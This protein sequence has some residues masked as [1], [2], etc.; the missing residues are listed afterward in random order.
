MRTS[1]RHFLAGSAAVGVGAALPVH[2]ARAAAPEIH[3]RPGTAQIAPEK[4]APTKIWGYEG[5]VPGPT[6]R[7]KQGER[8]VR[9]F[10]NEL[11]QASTIHWHGIRI[12]NAMDGVPGLTQEAVQTGDS[13]LYDFV[14]PDAGTYWYHPHNRTWEQLARGLYGAL[15]VEE[16]IKRPDIVC[17]A[18]P[19]GR[20][21]HCAGWPAA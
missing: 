1:R 16:H 21:D 11:P 20:M 7:V 4:Y 10:V 19:D 14:A 13:F 17:S 18:P 5:T 12:D 6:L 2:L 9:R 8:L 15:I 3:A